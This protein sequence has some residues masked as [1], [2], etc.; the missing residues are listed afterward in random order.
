MASHTIAPMS[1][2]GH[3]VMPVDMNVAASRDIPNLASV[4]L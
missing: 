1:K 4:Y 3:W 2:P